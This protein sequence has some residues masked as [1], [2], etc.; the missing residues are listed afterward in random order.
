MANL[1]K[2]EERGMAVEGT[3]TFSTEQIIEGVA[4]GKS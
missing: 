2:E 4:H 3:V 1:T